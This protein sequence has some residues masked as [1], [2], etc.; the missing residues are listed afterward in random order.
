M[1]RARREQCE[2]GESLR[3]GRAAAILTRPHLWALRALCL[4]SSDMLDS[5]I[6]KEI[7]I[8]CILLIL[9]QEAQKNQLPVYPPSFSLQRWPV[10]PTTANIARARDDF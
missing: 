1:P 2:P 6:P 8:K 7:L 5:S 4:L 10:I 3:P 9:C